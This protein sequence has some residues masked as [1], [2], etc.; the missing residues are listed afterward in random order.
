MENR[1]CPLQSSPFDA[2]PTET[3]PM[4]TRPTTMIHSIHVEN[5]KSL[6]DCNLKLA[7]LTLLVGLNGAGKS[8]V[9]HLLDFLGQLMRGDI[10]G[11]LD[12]R[13]WTS[14][15]LVSKF[16]PNHHIIKF[17]LEIEV[18]RQ[19]FLWCGEYD[20]REHACLTETV[21]FTDEHGQHREIKLTNPTEMEQTSGYLFPKVI[22]QYQGSILSQIRFDPEPDDENLRILKPF[23]MAMKR[24]RSLDLLSPSAMRRRARE[25]DGSIG[26][27]G[28]QLSAFLHEL[29]QETREKLEKQL[30]EVYGRKIK[31]ETSAMKAG[32][33]KLEVLETFTALN[34]PI[35]IESRHVN[36]GLLR[37]LA[38]LAELETDNT[39]PMFDEIENG[40]NS[41]LIAFLLERFRD[42]GKQI[43]VTT[44]SPMILNDL[45]DDLAR[46]GIIYIYRDDQGFSHA[47]KFF[48]IPAMAEKLK[49][50]GPGTAF[51]DTDLA[52]LREKIE[53][54]AVEVPEWSGS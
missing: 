20:H 35:T 28:E 9:L 46:E 50:M 31:I 53:P 25:S 51:V 24:V 23:V 26:P 10:K 18:D 8:S 39:L 52:R 13:K 5:F 48:E 21:D 19:R 30:S 14:D 43:L 6:V 47:M 22:F 7:P 27:E 49:V 11:W 34:D 33:K 29:S 42:S 44:H 40:I 2:T 1:L 36:D 16:K 45:E 17:R 12:R 41:E 54:V 32:W 37:L 4:L 38:I 3:K 15:D